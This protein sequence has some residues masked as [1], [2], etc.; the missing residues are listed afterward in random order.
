M[1]V[2]RFDAALLIVGDAGFALRTPDLTADRE[3]TRIDN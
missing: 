1:G 2:V 3:E